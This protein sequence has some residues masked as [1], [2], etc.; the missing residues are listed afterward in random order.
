MM[1]QMIRRLWAP[2]LLLAALFGLAVYGRAVWAA[3]AGAWN[4]CPTKKA[5]QR[6]EWRLF[7]GIP[8]RAIT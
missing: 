6:T 1:A 2:C 5:S 8:T 4:L 7:S 3:L